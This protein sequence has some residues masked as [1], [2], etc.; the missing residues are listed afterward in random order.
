MGQSTDAILF[1]G[2][3][4]SDEDTIFEFD[5]EDEW[6]EVLAVRRGADNPWAFYKES[7]AE[8]EH[9]LLPY[10]QQSVAYEAWKVEVGFDSLYE[11]WKATTDAIKVEF[12]VEIGT[13]CSCDYP[14]PYIAIPSTETRAYRG[15]PKRLEHP[16]VYP[17]G[18]EDSDEWNAELKRFVEELDIDVSDAEGPG[19]FLVSMWC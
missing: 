12:N 1:Y 8:T 15:G 7:G 17:N 10:A 6:Y 2:Y 9:M 14:M 16:S 5:N 19:W 18:Y 13:H 11:T 4:W 3:C